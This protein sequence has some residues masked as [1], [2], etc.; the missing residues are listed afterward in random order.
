MIVLSDEDVQ[1]WEETPPEMNT[2]TVMPRN[3][4]FENEDTE[5]NMKISK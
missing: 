1:W 5:K 2:L 3:S 4:S